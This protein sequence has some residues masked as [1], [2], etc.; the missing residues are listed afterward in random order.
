MAQI[1][2]ILWNNWETERH[3]DSATFQNSFGMVKNVKMPVE[4]FSFFQW[5]ATNRAIFSEWDGHPKQIKEILW[6]NYG[7]T[8]ISIRQQRNMLAYYI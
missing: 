5:C 2:P 6:R 7:K 8:A 4:N 1:C 3:A